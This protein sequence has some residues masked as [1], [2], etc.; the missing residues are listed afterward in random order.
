MRVLFIS[1]GNIA[2]QDN[3]GISPFIYCQGESLKRFGL[4]I[5]YFKI[6]GTG[7][8]GYFRNIF[9]LRKF[10]K[11]KNS[12]DIIHAHY[13]F[14]GI[15]AA[16][17]CP[18]LPIVISFMGDDLIGEIKNGKYSKTSSIFALLNRLLAC[19]VYSHSIVKSNHLFHKLFRRRN[20]TII[21]NGVDLN[22][23]FPFDKKE[24]IRVLALESNKKYVIFVSNPERPEKNFQLAL[25][26]F[27]YQ[28]YS[29]VVLMP[30]YQVQHNF[31]NN[32]YN[33]AECLLLTS[34]HEGSPNVIKEAMACGC[35][36]VST[37]VGDVSWVMGETK[38]C[39]ITPMDTR[40]AAAK[41]KCALE[42]AD[43]NNRTEG[44]KRIVEIGL[45]DDS[46][47]IRILNVYKKV[48]GIL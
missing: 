8:R 13:G 42:F 26:A 9:Y 20:A 22:N 37:D 24:A 46:V 12:F 44:R 5:E 36:I 38:G 34:Y 23:F 40:D 3:I 17:A 11:S 25:A 18:R 1:S 39:Y 45:D 33:A 19:V 35:P 4:D 48:L 7:L 30:V 29:D 6:I 16:L 14:C 32:Y 28:R 21:P 43:Q 10:F 2:S 31:L 27:N 41:L 47:A 15:V